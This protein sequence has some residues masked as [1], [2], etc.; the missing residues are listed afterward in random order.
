MTDK[1]R[2]GDKWRNAVRWLGATLGP[3]IAAVGGLTI[4]DFFPEGSVVA[5]LVENNLIISVIVLAAIGATLTWVFNRIISAHDERVLDEASKSFDEY[6][7]ELSASFFEMRKWFTNNPAERSDVFYNALKDYC[8]PLCHRIYKFFLARYKVN[9]HVCIKMID[10]RSMKTAMQTGDVGKLRLFTLA[11]S[12]ANKQEREAIELRGRELRSGKRYPRR[13]AFYEPDA[14]EEISD[15]YAMLLANQKTTQIGNETAAGFISQDMVRYRNRIVRFNKFNKTHG[16]NQNKLPIYRRYRTTS[17]KWWNKYRCTACIPIRI[18]KEYLDE[19]VKKYVA[20]SHLVVGFLCIDEPFPIN[21]NLMDQLAEYTKGFAH[22]LE[23]FFHEVAL[24]DL[25]IDTEPKKEE[26]SKAE[27]K[28]KDEI[29]E[30]GK[31]SDNFYTLWM[32]LLLKVKGADAVVELQK[33]LLSK[34][35]NVCPDIINEGDPFYRYEQIESDQ[36]AETFKETVG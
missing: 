27:G 30:N 18:R 26:N 2:N 31:F 17:G 20:G 6:H 28:S 3:A 19:E 21:K 29:P 8:E 23:G 5:D 7:E 35:A 34:Y 16:S 36:I 25:S 11:R 4:H 15:F 14:A 10:G 9:M 12:G 22:A 13:G 32:G 1:F 33:K 24:L